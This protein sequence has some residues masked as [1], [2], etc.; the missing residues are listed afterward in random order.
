MEVSFQYDKAAV[1]N[2]LRYHFLH[3]QETKML[4]I[5]FAVL[6]LLGLWGYLKGFF[7]Y[8]V[9]LIIF[10]GIILLTLVLYYVLPNVIYKKAKTFHEPSIKLEFNDGGVSIGTHAGAH[11]VSWQSFNRVLETNDFYY[12]YRNSNTFFLIPSS[13]FPNDTERND[14]SELLHR[15]F[16]NYAVK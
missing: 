6:F 11:H 9:V 5:L 15:H 7:P 12:L 13:A 3:R 4:R 10:I 16:S 8:A 2:A 1:I 14:F